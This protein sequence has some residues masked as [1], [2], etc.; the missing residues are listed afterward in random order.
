MPNSGSNPLGRESADEMLEELLS[1]DPELAPLKRTI[2][3]RTEGN[4]FFIEEIAQALFEQGVLVRNGAIKLVRPFSEG[5]IPTTVQGILSSRIDRLAP[6]EKE[7]LQTLAAIGRDF[8]LRLAKR[9]ANC[10]DA[11]LDRMLARLQSSEFIYEQPAAGDVEYTF[12][13]ALT[14]EVAYRSLLIERRN[15]LHERIGKAMESLFAER[16]DNHLKD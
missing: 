6:R 4:P 1:D 16:I 14:Q 11:E 15:L 10:S 5:T 2:A 13:H 8:P 3:R 9:V 7:L 12:K